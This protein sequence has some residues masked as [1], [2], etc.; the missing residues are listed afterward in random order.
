MKSKNDTSQPRRIVC[1]ILSCERKKV[2]Q[3]ANKLKG[4]D[5]FIN[6]IVVVELKR[7]LK[8]TETPS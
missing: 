2:L 1:K 3:N 7:A 6:K 4:A 8:G 5:S